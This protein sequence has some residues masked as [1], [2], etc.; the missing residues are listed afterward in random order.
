MSAAAPRHK[1]RHRGI[2]YRNGSNDPKA[3][4]PRRWIVWYRDSDGKGRTETLPE[5]STEKD[6][7]QRQA[8]LRGA[9]RRGERVMPTKQT[10]RDGGEAWFASLR[11][12]SPRTR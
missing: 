11:G 2:Y 7:L 8:E 9:K 12:K 1:S 4:G 6:A 10:L 3:P 5:G